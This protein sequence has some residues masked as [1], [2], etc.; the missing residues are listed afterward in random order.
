MAAVRNSTLVILIGF[1]FCGCEPSVS[2]NEPQPTDTKSLNEFP[3]KLQGEYLGK[4][5]NPL[6]RISNK[7]I[8][9]ISDFDIKAN[10]SELDSNYKLIGD[11]VFNLS[12]NTKEF[13][14]IERDTLV[15]HL[16]SEDTLFCITDK[17]ELKK[18]KGYYFLNFAD[19][20]TWHV[21]KLSLTK[22]ILSINRISSNEEISNLREITETT[23]DTTS[24]N[25]K[26]T[27]KQFNKFVKQDGFKNAEY[28]VRLK[29]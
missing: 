13:V 10:K 5:G 26:P 28:Y 4:E 21:W 7:L 3:K 15:Q 1:F 2:F 22:G 6:L 9:R 11:T 29:K 20:S 27:K 23:S 24:Y 14:R 17:N 16:H 18:F 8:Y 19:S 12:D 25:F